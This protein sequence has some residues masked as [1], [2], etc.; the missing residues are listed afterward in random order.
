MFNK[1]YLDKHLR[2]TRYGNICKHLKIDVHIE[3]HAFQ[4][5]CLAFE[6]QQTSKMIHLLRNV[7]SASSAYWFEDR[8][9]N[10]AVHA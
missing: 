9:I 6:Y 4:T 2:K 7:T 10:D 5:P 3:F 1:A 8:K